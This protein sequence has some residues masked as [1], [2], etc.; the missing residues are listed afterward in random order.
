MCLPAPAAAALAQGAG[1]QADQ[2]ARSVAGDQQPFA[3]AFS[4]AQPVGAVRGG[5]A[6]MRHCF[7]MTRA[8]RDG[9]C[10]AAATLQL[11]GVTIP[12]GELALLWERAAGATAGL[13]ACGQAREV[14]YRAHQTHTIRLP[15]WQQADHMASCP[16]AAAATTVVTLLPHTLPPPVI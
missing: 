14:Y 13:G 1:A 5:R 6:E 8:A 12:T 4:G 3:L 16:A 2:C 7:G 10:G 11:A 15:A 9:A